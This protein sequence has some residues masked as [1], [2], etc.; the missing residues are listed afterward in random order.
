MPGPKP[1]PDD[2][3]WMELDATLSAPARPERPE[4]EEPASGD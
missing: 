4:R 3:P 2:R 1:T